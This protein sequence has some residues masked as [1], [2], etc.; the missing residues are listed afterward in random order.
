[1]NSSDYIIFITFYW[2]VLA[3]VEHLMREDLVGSTVKL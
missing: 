1:M 2:F 3:V